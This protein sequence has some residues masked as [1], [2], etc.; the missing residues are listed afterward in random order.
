MFWIVLLLILLG[1]GFYFY[2]RLTDL[3]REIRAEQEREKEQQASQGSGETSAAALLEKESAQPLEQTISA[4]DPAAE[5]VENPILRIICTQ[6]GVVQSDLY[7]DL[8]QLNKKQAQQMV[9]ELVEAG[10]VR[11]ERQGSSFK[12]YLV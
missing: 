8:P 11:R 4:A 6:P 5:M 9:R 7:A 1:G 12:L 10:K 2:Q 3:E